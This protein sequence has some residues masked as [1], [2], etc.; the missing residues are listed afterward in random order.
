MTKEELIEEYTELLDLWKD[1][2]EKTRKEKGL[3]ADKPMY[4][5]VT[6][7]TKLFNYIVKDLMEIEGEERPKVKW[8]ITQGGNYLCNNCYTVSER[9]YDFCP[10]CG[11][12]MRESEED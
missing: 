8:E 6:I 4:V 3:S 10:N 12:E 7:I 1:N 2:I 5:E 9:E 11:A